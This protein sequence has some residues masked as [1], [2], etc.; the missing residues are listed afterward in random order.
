MNITFCFPGCWS[1]YFSEYPCCVGNSQITSILHIVTFTLADG[2]IS[3]TTC[4][5]L[6]LS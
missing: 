4:E 1:D 6:F 2:K 3:L 5:I